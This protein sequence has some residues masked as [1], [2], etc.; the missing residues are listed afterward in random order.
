MDK[1]VWR[2]LK[3][4]KLFLEDGASLTITMFALNEGT[5]EI[6]YVL[7]V[8]L[9][10]SGISL[11][12]MLFMHLIHAPEK[13]GKGC[14]NKLG[15]CIGWIFWLSTIAGMIG[16]LIFALSENFFGDSYIG[17]K[18]IAVFDETSNWNHCD[19]S[20]FDAHGMI[21]TRQRGTY[22]YICDYKE[23]GERYVD[24]ESCEEFNIGNRD[25]VI[26]CYDQV[27]WILS[28]DLDL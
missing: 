25:S 20:D 9:G 18:V 16:L 4:A 28:Y 21:C 15:M 13:K 6:T 3:I 2:W 7:M 26:A 12:F 5:I 23:T 22:R 19:T 1:V 27:K 11:V 24:F 8:S 17:D 14:C 10:M